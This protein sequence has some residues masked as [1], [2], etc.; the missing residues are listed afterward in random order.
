M[1]FGKQNSIFSGA[2][3]LDYSPFH[4]P[5]ILVC[6]TFSFESQVL[7]EVAPSW[8]SGVPV[9]LQY[10]KC[11]FIYVYHIVL[12]R[13]IKTKVRILWENTDE[14]IATDYFSILKKTPIIKQKS[15]LKTAPINYRHQQITMR[16]SHNAMG[17]HAQFSYD[18]HKHLSRT[19]PFY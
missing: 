16:K 11:H 8:P 15:F 12:R 9:K 3:V 6:P 10:I 7:V 4:W 5:L 13:I 17:N 19:Q 14:N 2:F 18:L 1:E